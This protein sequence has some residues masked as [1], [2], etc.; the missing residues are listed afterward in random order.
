MYTAALLL[1]LSLTA[2]S[3][4]VF[5]SQANDTIARRNELPYKVVDV[6]G[7]AAPP[8]ETVT[9]TPSP[10]VT[11]TV[12]EYPSSTPALEPFSL[13]S[14]SVGPRVTGIPHPGPQFAARGLNSTEHN[15]RRH[16]QANTTVTETPASEDSI[17]VAKR[18]NDT[19]PRSLG[20]HN[21]TEHEHHAE[22]KDDDIS[23]KAL[24]QRALTSTEAASKHTGSNA[25]ETQ[26]A[27]ADL[28]PGHAAAFA[29]RALT[30]GDAKPTPQNSNN[31]A[32]Q[33]DA[34]KRAINTTEAATKHFARSLN[35]TSLHARNVT[36]GDY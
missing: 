16:A 31:T 7:T 1:A 3:V 25:N 10:P 4:P 21:G 17:T 18:S 22:H 28:A 12:T 11:V 30:T 26:S 14:W 34:T 35:G 13:S 24:T 15:H 20:N 27:R 33:S 36:A 8:V 32:E 23:A 19:L 6:A 2:Q 29:R 9:A 5:H